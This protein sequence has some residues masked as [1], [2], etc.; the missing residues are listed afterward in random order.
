MSGPA[1]DDLEEIREQLL[2]LRRQLLAF[3]QEQAALLAAV[4]AP[5]RASARNLLHFVAFHRHNHHRP[6]Q[7][8][9]QE[10]LR[11]RG[12]STLAGCDPHLLASLNGVI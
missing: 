9:L 10:A 7:P 8:S 2:E 1:A 5:Y 6:R 11:R 12:L 4:A 3:E